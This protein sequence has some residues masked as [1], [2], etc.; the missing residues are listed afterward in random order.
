MTYT[1][2]AGTDRPGSNT[3]KVAKEYQRIL[4]EKGVTAQLLSLETEDVTSKNGSF[5]ALQE[6]YLLS[7]DKYI[8]VLPEYNG[9]FPGILKLLIDKSD[10]KNAWWNKKALLTGVATGRA[11]NLRGLEHLTGSLMHLKMQVHHNRLPISMVDKILDAAGQFS[12]EGTIKVIAQQ[13]DEYI[14]F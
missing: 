11:G 14:Q 13:L 3:L 4:A 7:T 8:F 1:I 6:Q 5:T 2:I 12:D 10:V 9:S